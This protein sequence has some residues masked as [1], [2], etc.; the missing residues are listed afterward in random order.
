LPVVEPLPLV[1]DEL[2]EAPVVEPVVPEVVAVD[3][4]VEVE[5]LLA[6]LAPVLPLGPAELPPTALEPVEPAPL[7]LLDDTA[8][9]DLAVVDP[10]PAAATATAAR[11]NSAMRCMETSCANAR[12]AL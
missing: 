2:L 7:P 8:P 5:V 1:V 11:V 4:E 10:Q 3:V 9:A 12:A 6:L